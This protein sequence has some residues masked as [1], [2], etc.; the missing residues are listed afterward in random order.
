M[1][2]WEKG[3][4]GEGKDRGMRKEERYMG[5]LVGV[6]NVRLYG[7]RREVCARCGGVRIQ[8][9]GGMRRGCQ[10]VYIGQMIL[11]WGISGGNG[12]GWAKSL[13]AQRWWRAGYG[14]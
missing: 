7:G 10:S 11:M 4:K 8:L 2:M 6:T 1:S 14:P 9:G 12:G 3:C 5:M 13:T